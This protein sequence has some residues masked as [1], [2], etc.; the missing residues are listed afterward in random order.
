MG[1]DFIGVVE[2]LVYNF[3]HNMYIFVQIGTC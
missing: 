2:G 3:V 1:V